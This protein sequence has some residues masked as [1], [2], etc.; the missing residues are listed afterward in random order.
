MGRG[1]TLGRA[2]NSKITPPAGS[3]WAPPAN[4]HA[5]CVGSELRGKKGGGAD[6]VINRF[7]AASKAC[8]GK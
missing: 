3:R 1:R 4:S 8:R 7:T 2:M 6:G 5:R